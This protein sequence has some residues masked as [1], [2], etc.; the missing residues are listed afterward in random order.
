MNIETRITE[1][2]RSLQ[3]A[4]RAPDD[5]CR[6]GAELVDGRNTAAEKCVNGVFSRTFDID[7]FNKKEIGHTPRVGFDRPTR[8][9]SAGGHRTARSLAP[10]DELPPRIR[11]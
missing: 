6:A 2:G 4:S 7:P 3:V 8:E 11:R 1:T 5:A 10:K 9:I